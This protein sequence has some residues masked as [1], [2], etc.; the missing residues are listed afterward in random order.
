[1]EERLTE[2][3]RI[4]GEEI[5]KGEADE[6]LF[7]GHSVGAILAIPV[8]SRL[9]DSHVNL[10]GKNVALLTLGQCIPLVSFLPHA[11]LFRNELSTVAQAGEITW[12]DFSSPAD[13]VCFALVDPVASS[14][15]QVPESR[16]QRPKLM[17]ARFYKSITE[18]RYR[19]IRR[20]GKR[21][22]FQY[23]MAVDVPGEYDFFALTAGGLAL[24]ERFPPLSDLTRQD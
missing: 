12:I 8:L 14:G 22:H 15:I 17:N 11:K 23:L 7:I 21:L 19:K 5:D 4:A 6:Y 9:M 2:F 20:D 16:T 18:D 10:S 1:M 13:P 3:A 24:K